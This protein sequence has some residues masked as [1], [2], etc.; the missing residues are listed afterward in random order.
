MPYQLALR[1]LLLEDQVET[2]DGQPLFASLGDLAQAVMV[3]E[4]VPTK[5][6]SLVPMIQQGLVGSRPFKKERAVALRQAVVERIQQRVPDKLEELTGKFDYALY[7]VEKVRRHPYQTTSGAKWLVG[8]D[9]GSTFAIVPYIREVIT[10][11]DGLA[12]VRMFIASYGLSGR[13]MPTN[14]RQRHLLAFADDEDIFAFLSVVVSESAYEELGERDRPLK[15]EH[16]QKAWMRL[17]AYSRKHIL[18]FAILPASYCLSSVTIYDCEREEGRTMALSYGGE[19]FQYIQ[20]HGPFRQ[21]YRQLYLDLMD[22][23]IEGARFVVPSDFHAKIMY[24]LL[25]ASAVV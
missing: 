8:E 11:K 21:G 24:Q 2:T 1:R 13:E 16:I 17:E 5:K 25:S 14:F 22:G 10:T 6:E 23:K 7:M 20:L 3:Y 15:Q 19:A 4:L 18:Q 12:L 9:I